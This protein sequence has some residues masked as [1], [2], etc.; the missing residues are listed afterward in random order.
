MSYKSFQNYHQAN[1]NLIPFR[2][3]SHPPFKEDFTNGDWNYFY[4][5]IQILII[6]LPSR[7]SIVK[8][9][10]IKYPNLLKKAYIIDA[11]LKSQL[12]LD[13]LNKTN[14]IDINSFKLLKN[15]NENLEGQIAC[16]LSHIETIKY[17]LKMKKPYLLIL[18]DDFEFENNINEIHILKIILKIIKFNFDCINL[19][20]CYA[21]PDQQII[22]NIFLKEFGRCTHSL[23]WSKQG[24]NNLL[25]YL[26]SNPLN[27]AYDEFLSDRNEQGDINGFSLKNRLFTQIPL[28]SEINENIVNQ[29]PEYHPYYFNSNIEHFTKSNFNVICFWFGKGLRD[30]PLTNNRIQALK[31]MKKEMG[32][33]I[34]LINNSNLGKYINKMNIKLHPA[35]R[36]LSANHIS[37]Y[38]RV[39]FANHFPSQLIGYSDIKYFNKSWLPSFQLLQKNK[40]LQLIGTKLFHKDWIATRQDTI[41]KQLIGKHNIIPSQGYWIARKASPIFKQWLIKLNNIL[42]TKLQL[43]KLNPAKTDRCCTD[44]KNSTYPIDYQPDYPIKWNEICGEIFQPLCLKYIKQISLTLPRPWDDKNYNKTKQ[45]KDG[46]FNYL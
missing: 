29:L 9:Q 19:G 23:L 22:N 37:D 11:I 13:I 43:L 17:F 27:R 14:Q 4:K 7:K 8:S 44:I 38:L 5:N 42:D 41:N 30:L 34:I 45:L 1:N 20:K 46:F 32:V 16:A 10:L 6:T 18:E 36:Y 33:N 25:K 28:K 39:L 24:C 21:K 40:N 35:I 15:K 2:Y 12:Q 26:K 31:S 3:I